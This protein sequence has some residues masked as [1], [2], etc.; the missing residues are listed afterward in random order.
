MGIAGKSRRQSGQRLQVQRLL[1]VE[2]GQLFFCGSLVRKN[3]RI[4]GGQAR[5]VECF[6]RHVQRVE[7]FQLD[8]IL[9]VHG[10]R[11]GSDAQ[12]SEGSEH[13]HE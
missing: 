12:Q 5:L 2:D 8:F 6:A 13:Q 7:L 3:I 1:T 4:A 10:A 11:D 9:R